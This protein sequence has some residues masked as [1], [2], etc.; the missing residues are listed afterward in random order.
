MISFLAWLIGRIN[1][2]S[3]RYLITGQS[4]NLNYKDIT[5]ALKLMKTGRYV[6]LVTRKSHLSTWVICLG[7]YIACWMHGKKPNIG[8]Y[9]HCFL[10]LEDDLTDNEGFQIVEA[11]EKGCKISEFWDVLLVDSIC[12]LRPK[13]YSD[14]QLEEM[15]NISKKYVGLPYDK[16]SNMHDH[17][18]VN[19]VEGQYAAL[20]SIDMNGLPN[21]N[22]WLKSTKLIT[23]DMIRDCGD[24]EIVYETRR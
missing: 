20:M 11:V 7:H 22:A 13:N 9:G 15:I 14:D 21:L 1:F 17:S 12:L 24:Y 2:D 18:S 5:D 10:H 8:K 6:G 3:I 23:P 16:K 4:Y 19:C